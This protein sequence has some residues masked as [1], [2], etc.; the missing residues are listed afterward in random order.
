LHFHLNVPSFSFWWENIIE[1]QCWMLVCIN[2]QQY[3]PVRVGSRVV[4]TYN[5]MNLFGVHNSLSRCLFSWN[6]VRFH[7]KC[8]RSQSHNEIWVCLVTISLPY[9]KISNYILIIV[10]PPLMFVPFHWRNSFEEIIWWQSHIYWTLSVSAVTLY[11][12]LKYDTNHHVWI[13]KH[14]YPAEYLDEFFV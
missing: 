6:S 4:E 9:R 1:T 11:L 14:L 3:L 12:Y 8:G 2:I 13:A 7:F 10:P 5:V